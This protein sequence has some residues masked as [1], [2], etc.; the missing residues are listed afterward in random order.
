MT[1]THDRNRHAKQ[2]NS[3]DLLR[4]NVRLARRLLGHAIDKRQ[5]QSLESLSR[6][7]HFSIRNGELQLLNNSWYVTH[8]GL[9][10]LARRKKCQGIHVEAVDSLCDS[11]ASRFVMKATV[12]PSKGSAGF[13]GCGDADPSKCSH[14][15]SWCRAA[16]C[17]NPRSQSRPPQSVWH[18][19]LLGRGDG[20]VP[21]PTVSST[22]P[23][24]QP[25]PANDSSNSNGNGYNGNGHKVRDRLCQII[26]QHKLDPELVKAYAVDFCGT[27]AL[28]DATRE[29]VEEF[30][31]QLADSAQEEPERPAVPAQQLRAHGPGGRGMKR[32]IPGLSATAVEDRSRWFP[33]VSF[34][35]ALKAPSIAGTPRSRFTFFGCRF[36]NPNRLPGCPSL[37]GSIARR[38]RCGSW[39]GFCA[40]FCTTRSC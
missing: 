2:R 40:I 20:T 8:T 27:E 24:V 10:R 15:C 21:M 23:K 33:T 26:R 35:S 19:H 36:S 1:E 38:K 14:A 31:Q 9:V 3:S 16:D 29:Q 11:A 13:V 22:A 7:F 37:A 28:K 4:E 39:A 12:Y 32:H 34:L 18:R 5:T 17:R 6:D 30:V 25:S